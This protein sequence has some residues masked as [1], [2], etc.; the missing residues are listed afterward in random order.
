MRRMFGTTVLAVVVAS[1]TQA[2]AHHSNPLFFDMSKAITLEGT[3]VRVEWINPH[4]LLFL[5]SKNEKGE[6]ETWILQG[7]SL[8]NANRQV[9]LKERLQPGISISARVW[10]PRNPLFLNDAQTVLPT[11]PD[12]ARQSSRIVGGGQIRF[13]D[14][15]VLAFG[16]GPTF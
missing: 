2:T 4:V 11:R 12:D 15:D 9:G 5:Q 6:L 8:N 10:P 3:V 13:S 14:G 16:G 1:G 7:A